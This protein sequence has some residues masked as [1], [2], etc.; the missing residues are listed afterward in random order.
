MSKPA[1]IN[2][3]P[4][5]CPQILRKPFLFSCP[6]GGFI[7]GPSVPKGYFKCWGPSFLGNSN[8]GEGARSSLGWGA[9][10]RYPIFRSFQTNEVA[11]AAICLFRAPE[12]GTYRAFFEKGKDI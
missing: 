11:S 6:L 10:S 7:K 2:M 1:K 4:M 5:P 9:A 8:K 3:K 12:K